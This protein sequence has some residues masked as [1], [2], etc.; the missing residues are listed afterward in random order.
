[1]HGFLILACTISCSL[2]GFAD[3]YGPF[4]DEDAIEAIL[5]YVEMVH[6]E[7]IGG[8]LA[9]KPATIPQECPN[10]P[11]A[12]ACPADGLYGLNVI[13]A[14]QVW[15]ILP[16]IVNQNPTVRV[17][18]ADSGVW[19]THADLTRNLVPGLSLNFRNGVPGS[20]P[21]TD[22][23]NTPFGGGL[24]VNHGTHV[25]GTVFAA[26]DNGANSAVGVVGNALGI[27]C[28]LDYTESSTA[29]CVE[30]ARNNR[31]RVINMSFYTGNGYIAA[32]E[33]NNVMRQQFELFCDSGGLIIIAA[34]NFGTTVV[35]TVDGGRRFTYPQA[36]VGDFSSKHSNV[37]E[38]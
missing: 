2:A 35:R 1:M 23:D 29:R 7:S 18:V 22:F 8:L 33:A 4:S 5:K 31:V 34:G 38:Q 28:G 26:H 16:G 14:P 32:L 3:S 24:Q 12:N 11:A 36:F 25:S 20:L 30:Y 15:N 9:V 17:M 21:P 10:R 6:G 13:R 37:A 19:T 27:S